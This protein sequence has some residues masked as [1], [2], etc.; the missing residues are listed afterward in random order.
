[1]SMN[2]ST[3]DSAE[4]G[5]NS[6]GLE[7]TAWKKA[8]GGIAALLLAILF[9]ASGSWKLADPYKWSQ[10]LTEF[11]VPGNIALEFTLALGIGESFGAVMILVPRFRRWGSWLIA[12]LLAA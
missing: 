3:A 5:L 8:I 4:L 2:E 11:K 6:V 12:F 10:F 1:M 7:V 9:F